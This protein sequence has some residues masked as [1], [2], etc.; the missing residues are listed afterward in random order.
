M[1]WKIPLSLQFSSF[2]LGC[3]L[4]PAQ[5]GRWSFP[6][7]TVALQG[8]PGWAP[9]GS[10]R[11]ALLYS[12]CPGCLW[13]QLEGQ[14]L[15]GCGISS[16]RGALAA[17]SSPALLEGAWQDPLQCNIPE[18]HQCQHWHFCHTVP[19]L[20][21]GLSVGLWGKRLLGPITTLPG[22]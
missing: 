18:A 16:A 13:T 12:R 8:V 15:G 11:A 20:S 5:G 9:K 1:I 22:G 4:F 6:P 19:G 14:A 21:F 17:L 2:T 10:G 7:G 3:Q